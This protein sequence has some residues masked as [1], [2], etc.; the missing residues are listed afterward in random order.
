MT[1]RCRPNPIVPPSSTDG[2]CKD[3]GRDA[4]TDV[5]HADTE[6]QGTRKRTEY[7]G[8]AMF[9]SRRPQTRCTLTEVFIDLSK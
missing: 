5:G 4:D 2:W 6:L 9:E 1:A 8:I 7:G 3:L